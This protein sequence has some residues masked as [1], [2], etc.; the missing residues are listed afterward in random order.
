LTQDF[1]DWL[2]VN[3][4]TAPSFT[5]IF[6]PAID[7]WAQRWF[8][9]ER[10]ALRDAQLAGVKRSS[11]L[12]VGSCRHLTDDICV[13]WN[14]DAQ[15]ALA[16]LALDVRHDMPKLTADDQKL[17]DSF[18][19][20]IFHDLAGELSKLI[21]SDAALRA[22]ET[23]TPFTTEAGVDLHIASSD[24]Q[25]AFILAIAAPALFRLRKSQCSRYIPDKLAPSP[26]INILGS[27]PVAFRAKLGKADMSALDL[28]DMAEGDVVVLNRA[29]A[30][31]LELVSELSGRLLFKARL[32][33]QAG[34]LALIACDI[35]G[36]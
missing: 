13:S 19:T 8:G 15:A 1:R 18:V 22:D 4:I 28:H 3:A 25:V 34:E 29:V 35:E 11:K 9:G 23:V 36:N 24:D 26:V 6:G 20:R 2:P 21:G 31:P 30:E 7:V 32:E 17:I 33:Q 12:A 27:A 10:L 14:E 16:Q 5:A